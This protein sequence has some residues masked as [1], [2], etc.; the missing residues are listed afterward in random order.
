[1]TLS[2]DQAKAIA[3]SGDDQ[4]RVNLAEQSDIAPELLYYLAGDAVPEVRRAVAGN[5]AA[6]MHADVLL[7]RDAD[8]GVRA[9]LAEKIAGPAAA[10]LYAS[11]HLRE[12]AYGALS[13]L[14]K[15]Q[16][17]RIRQTI[18]E[19]LR[20]VA[21]AP[22]DVIRRLAWDVE[23][24]VATPILKYSPVLNDSDLIEIILAR[25]SPGSI[26]A[27]SARIGVSA[28]VSHAIVDSADI[29]GIA[30]LLGNK[31]A[32]IREETLDRVIADA[33]HINVWHMPLA[34]RPK[35]PSKLAVKIA[36]VVAEDVLKLMQTR[37]D[38]PDNVATAVRKVV[39]ERLA[40]GV[41]V[42]P[43]DLLSVSPKGD[44]VQLDDH[45]IFDKAAKLWAEGALDEAALVREL[46]EG[47]GKFAKAIIAVMADVPFVI[48]QQVC[49]GHS[50]KNCVALAWRAGLSA[51]TATLM[52]E[53]LCR[54]KP[55]NVLRTVDGSYP[56]SESEMIW[57]VDIFLRP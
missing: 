13:L 22:P 32:Q 12:L 55:D 6:P 34:M 37:M 28:D 53:K 29:E 7:A 25:P 17:V 23:A 51:E 15:D 46:M 2:Y 8:A 19:A 5:I 4:A 24:V 47:D 21:D 11:D 43:D 20:E 18:A 39:L 45:N 40:D 10:G 49:S 52:Q 9:T 38:L 14:A 31:S 30:I 33:A 16:V 27:V 41:A 54:I 50:A 36:R 35:L 1:M 26:S 44:G 48:V 3:H 57:Q 42:L 56:L